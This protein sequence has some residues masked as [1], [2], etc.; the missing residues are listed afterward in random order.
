MSQDPWFVIG[1]HA[2]AHLMQ[3]IGI[4]APTDLYLSCRVC[5]MKL[6]AVEPVHAHAPPS[7]DMTDNLFAGQRR[8]AVGK[9]NKDV[10][11]TADHDR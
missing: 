11:N 10:I 5:V 8:A 7:A 3:E 2:Q 1:D 4:R 9:G 6:A